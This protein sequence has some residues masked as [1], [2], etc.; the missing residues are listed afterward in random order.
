MDQ[1]NLKTGW[2]WRGR[3]KGRGT[4]MIPRYLIEQMMILK[5]H[6]QIGANRTEQTGGRWGVEL[7]AALLILSFHRDIWVEELGRL[8][9]M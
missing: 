7:H 6:L 8:S 1:R 3:S 9:E 4:E 5:C 2:V